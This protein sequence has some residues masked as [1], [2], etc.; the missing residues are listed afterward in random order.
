LLIQIIVTF[1]RQQLRDT[2]SNARQAPGRQRS[3]I[4]ST[5]LDDPQA[6]ESPA[7][8]LAAA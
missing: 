1:Y 6:I 2:A 4:E 8:S 3:Q 7:R 5:G